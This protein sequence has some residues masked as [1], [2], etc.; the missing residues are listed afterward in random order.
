MD[1]TNTEIRFNTVTIEVKNIVV[2]ETDF[3]I[4]F[5]KTLTKAM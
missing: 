2:I 3:I 1:T 4:E 5:S